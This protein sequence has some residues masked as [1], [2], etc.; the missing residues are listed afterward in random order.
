MMDY[1]WLNIGSFVLGIIAWTTPLLSLTSDKKKRNKKWVRMSFISFSACS[2][3]LCFQIF[4]IY[5]KVVIEDWWALIDTMY[6]VAIASATLLVVTIILNAITL[7]A[8]RG[9]TTD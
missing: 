1:V 4:Y 3:S 8:S 9:I 5:H 7:N 6:A 2:I